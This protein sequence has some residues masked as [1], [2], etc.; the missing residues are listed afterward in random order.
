MEMIVGTSDLL[1]FH[2]IRA[3]CTEQLLHVFAVS[4]RAMITRQCRL[5]ISAGLLK[6]FELLNT[7][8][9]Q[10]F[11]WLWIVLSVEQSGFYSPSSNGFWLQWRS[12]HGHCILQPLQP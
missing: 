12:P 3:E 11:L 1:D 7:P 10:I 4:Y 6:I 5:G 8:M 2:S 9:G